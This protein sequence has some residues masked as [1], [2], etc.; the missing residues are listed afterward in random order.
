M[1]LPRLQLFD[2]FP[3]DDCKYDGFTEELENR[4]KGKN[5]LIR[6]KYIVTKS[7][8]RPWS[9][10]VPSKSTING[11]VSNSSMR[12]SYCYCDRCVAKALC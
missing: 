11:V 6:Q 12:I 2:D 7:N 9:R 5:H 1:A 4:F 8:G 3:C 10:K